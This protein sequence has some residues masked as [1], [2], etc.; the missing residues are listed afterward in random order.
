MQ[1]EQAVEI[2]QSRR[3]TIDLPREMPAGKAVIIVNCREENEGLP[4]TMR[5]SEA[6]LA[7]DWNS[8]EEEKAW[9]DL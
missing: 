6:A 9:A 8:P 3:L 4:A 5:L 2:P 7:E 1:Y